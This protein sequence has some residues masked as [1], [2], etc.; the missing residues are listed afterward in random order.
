MDSHSRALNIS[1]RIKIG[2][3]SGTYLKS[4]QAKQNHREQSYGCDLM[5]EGYLKQTYDSG[6]DKKSCVR[7]TG[8]YRHF[9][10]KR[11]C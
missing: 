2:S 9:F 3:G 4:E 1:E 11:R 8:I 5:W 6:E 10:W 7:E